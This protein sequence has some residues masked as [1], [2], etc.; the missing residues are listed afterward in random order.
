MKAS[1]GVRLKIIC[2]NT[3]RVGSRGV[4]G[5]HGF[6][7]LVECGGERVLFDTGPSQTTMLNNIKAVDKAEGSTPSRLMVALSH[8]H[9]DHSGGLL[10]LAE[11]GRYKCVVHAHPDAFLRRYKKTRGRIEEIS[12]PFTRERLQAVAEIM[13]SR[14]P[15]MLN[16]WAM[17]SGEVERSSFEVP[18]TEFFIDRGGAILKDPFLD[19]QSMFIN[20][21]GKGLA[22]VTGCA[23]SGIINIIDH[24]RRI[25][26]VDDICAVIG[27]FHMI[28]YSE[29][30]MAKTIDL[31]KERKPLSLIPCHC[32]GIEG[33]IALREGLGKSVKPCAAGVEISI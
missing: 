16:S 20:I 11:C 33:I 7:A 19:D 21:D 31:L 10:G 17:L 26:G 28:D 30:K 29:G 18:E 14:E 13:E 12:M 2:D 15:V 27:G 22:I 32:T 6:S 4:L 25:T 5:E 24:A 8:G 1:A 3:V 9:F 23:H